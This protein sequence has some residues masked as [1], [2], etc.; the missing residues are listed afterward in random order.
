MASFQVFNAVAGELGA[1]LIDFSTDGFKAILSNTVPN[2]ATQVL[3]AS[4]T[5]VAAGNGYTAGGV[6][7]T[8]MTY[9]SAVAGVYI[10]SSADFSWTA[11]GG[12]IANFRYI[13]I[14]DTT[15]SGSPL[16]S[17][18]DT[19]SGGITIA[20]GTTW[21]FTVGT[22]GLARIVVSTQ[23]GAGAFV[24]L[25]DVP[26]SYAG[27]AGKAVRVNPAET[28][29]EFQNPGYVT[30]NTQTGDYTF[31]L[32]DAGKM[33]RMNS[34]SAQNLTVPLNS[35]V[36]FNIGDVIWIEQIGA[37]VLTI[38]ATGG[39]TINTPDDLVY[40]WQNQ[41]GRL[42]KVGTDTWDLE[43]EVDSVGG[44]STFT[45]LSDVPGSYSGAGLKTVRVNAGGTGLEFYSPPNIPTT[46]TYIGHFVVDDGSFA[47]PFDFGNFTTSSSGL[48]VALITGLSGTSAITAASVHFGSQAANLQLN[49]NTSQL[50]QII[51]T[52]AM[53]A[54][55]Y[56]ITMTPS[57]TT[58]NSVYSVYVYLIQ[59]YAN[60][61][62]SSIAHKETTG[63]GQ[64]SIADNAL[65]YTT[66]GAAL[67]AAGYILNTMG[68]TTWSSASLDVS[69]D[70][71]NGAEW[72]SAHKTSLVAGSHVETASNGS[73]SNGDGAMVCGAV[74]DA[75]APAAPVTAFTGLSDVP[76]SY[77]GGTLKAVRVN[78]GETALEFYTPAGP[79]YNVP[80]IK[81]PSASFFPTAFNTAT[82][83]DYAGVGMGITC[84]ANGSILQGWY[85]PITGGNDTF[86]C[87]I[88][89]TIYENDML[90]A[91][92]FRQ[93]SSAGFYTYGLLY[94][95]GYFIASAEWTTATSFHAGVT[96]N[97]YFGGPVWLK[98]EY[99]AAT[100]QL[101]FSWS[102]DGKNW[103]QNAVVDHTGWLSTIESVG[104]GVYSTSAGGAGGVPYG[105]ITY[106]DDSVNHGTQLII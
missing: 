26:T 91:M 99:V 52:H 11:S 57:A 70:D 76:G 34:G 64:T 13:Y 47:S 58:H 3:I 103:I 105:L 39:V 65:T 22:A 44:S 78:A 96:Y 8:G 56:D 30:F 19:G 33:I 69:V 24:L 61:T 83:T 75:G 45:G 98:A 18:V 59:N 6:A 37:G 68:G 27:Q 54:G 89:P 87:R 4:V 86:I 5:D 102:L 31:V 42:R 2:L 35:S 17:V 92:I 49:V 97:P 50:V 62:P 77:A 48:L 85:K 29:L 9:S 16:I 55:T 74:W 25:D 23:S 101:T 66:D 84:A 28:G 38:V 46:V 71:F 40:D 93:T 41:V 36:A 80:E 95:N 60:E 12:D 72:S 32:T 20:D 106:W 15:A 51:A 21:T 67:Y 73:S 63:S 94:E 1:S 79:S 10:F 81:P 53:P 7:L 82:L 88:E 90:V 14:Y 43:V 104:V 100:Y